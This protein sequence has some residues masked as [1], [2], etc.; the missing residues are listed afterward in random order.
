MRNRSVHGGRHELGQNFLVH[1]PT[2]T[3]L[4]DLIAETD[5]PILEIGVGDGALTVP[6]AAL[7]RPLRGIDLDEHRVARLRR[8]LPAVDIAQADAMRE[9][10]DRPV[11]VGNLPFHITTPLLRRLLD[12]P[13]WHH[14][15]VLTQWEVARKR[16]GIGGTTMMTAQSA[17]WFT[18]ELRGR[19]PR[20]GFRP[21][22]N[23]DGGILAIRRRPRPLL[24]GVDRRAYERFVH[25][26]FTS[27]GRGMAGV[28]RT[29]SVADR[30][31]IEQALD[32]ASIER[33]ALPRDLTAVQ[34]SALWNDVGGRRTR[35]NRRSAGRR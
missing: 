34:W 19:V 32:R 23:V 27:A 7:G 2:I 25:A 30:G 13:Q 17:P 16:A 11:V 33:S 14:A 26:V 9:P 21:R 22:P 18:F 28:L 35:R 5:G 20:H 10:L 8:R 12:A 6:L 29:M 15:I 3:T 31:S 24:T 1:R 4:V